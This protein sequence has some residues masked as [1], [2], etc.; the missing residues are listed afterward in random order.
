MS[1]GARVVRAPDPT[2]YC[3][4]AHQPQPRGLGEVEAGTLS[5]LEMGAIAITAMAAAPIVARLSPLRFALVGVVLAVAAQLASAFVEPYWKVAGAAP[6][7]TRPRR[8]HNLRAL[9]AGRPSAALTCSDRTGDLAQ[10]GRV[11]WHSPGRE[12]R[13]KS[14]RMAPGSVVR[15]HLAG[16][17]APTRSCGGGNQPLSPRLPAP[18]RRR[19]AVTWITPGDT[20]SPRRWRRGAPGSRCVPRLGRRPRHARENAGT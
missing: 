8:G 5:T 20:R 7:S 12:K 1:P 9:Y 16:G 3:G 11:A 10:F 2:R 6:W 14:A 4:G 15:C 18:D 19:G 13:R 17:V